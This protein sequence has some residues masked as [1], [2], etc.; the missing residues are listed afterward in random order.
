MTD[1]FGGAAP[2]YAKYRAGHGEPAI[3]RLAMTFGQDSTVLDL[4]CGPGTVAIPLARR[5]REVLAVDPDE[6]MLAEGRRLAAGVANIRWL[7]GDSTRLR[8]LPAFDHIVMGRSFHWMDRRAV[9]A[10]LDEL[11]PADGVVALVGPGRDPGEEPGEE[12]MR[13]VRDEF[14][15]NTFTAA[16]S[17]QATG[18]HPH[19]VLAGSPFADLES[20]TY[21]RRLTYDLDAVLGL[22]L[23]Y[24][25]TSP[26][27][28][29]DRLEAFTE[30][31]RKA[32]LASNPSGRWEQVTSTEVLVARRKVTPGS[33]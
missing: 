21:E 9:L 24:S 3:E 17:Y 33:A 11:L 15:V 20:T 19:D 1:L 25:Y 23:S 32:L 26:A 13:P 12:A 4:G 6:E 30:A 5:V 28:L 7:P 2:Y 16:N 18:E 14:E 31:A 22:Q 8:E 29:G 27:R 10:E